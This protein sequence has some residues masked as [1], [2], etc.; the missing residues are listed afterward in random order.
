MA[1]RRASTLPMHG[2][3]PPSRRNVA[4]SRGGSM[5]VSGVTPKRRQT[6]SRRRSSTRPVQLYQYS[7]PP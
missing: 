3:V 2:T 5:V 4:S 7:V 6:V 1:S